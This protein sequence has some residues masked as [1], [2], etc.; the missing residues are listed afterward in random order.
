MGWTGNIAN[1]I[2][3]V[4]LGLSAF[5]LKVEATWLGGMGSTLYAM[6]LRLQA[7]D[8]DALYKQRETIAM[9]QRAEQIWAERLAK[10][11]KDFEAAWKL[12][13]AR[14]WLGTPRPGESREQYLEGGIAAGPAAIGTTANSAGDGCPPAR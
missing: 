11:P 4:T 14:Y 1:A 12:A 2:L 13:R 6:E 8:P 10:N 3:A 5:H 7:E 9:A